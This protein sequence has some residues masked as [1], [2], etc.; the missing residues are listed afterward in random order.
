MNK[1]LIITG[2]AGF[3]GLNFILEL[4]SHEMRQGEQWNDLQKVVSNPWIKER[5]EKV[6]LLDKMGYATGYNTDVYH[7]VNPEWWTKVISNI[8]NIDSWSQYTKGL[9]WDIV[10][11]A[12]ESHVEN[13]INNPFPFFSENSLLTASLVTGLGIENINVFIHASTDEVYGELSTSMRGNKQVWFDEALNASPN[14]PYSASKVAQ[15]AFLQSMAHTFGMKVILF[16]MGNQFGGYQHPEKFFPV[17]VLRS[18]N[19]EK[20]KIH[21]D[22]SNIR[23]WTP[24]KDTVKQLVK[25]LKNHENYVL[26]HN[27]RIIHLASQCGLM[28]NLEVVE[29]WRDIL[30]NDFGIESDI[31]FIENRKGNDTMY[32]S[33]MSDEFNE[34][35]ND[36]RERFSEGIRHYIEFKDK[37]LGESYQ[38]TI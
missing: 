2:A 5:Y 38:Y 33:K 12:S 6:I 31:E 25:I 26:D 29:L 18:L 19:G 7:S 21:G 23:Q 36:N 13:S 15:D 1:G 27:T 32:A 4:D 10:D 17:S 20:I 8:N 3:V 9:K 30:K 37:Y 34:Y 22:G 24:V 35:P 11:F 28:T 16:R 14:N